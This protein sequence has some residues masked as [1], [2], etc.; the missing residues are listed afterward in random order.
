MVGAFVAGAASA[1]I[2]VALGQGLRFKLVNAKLMGVLI[3][4]RHA[5]SPDYTSRSAKRI[6]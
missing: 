1:L 5:A 6:C 3:S 4:W 2:G